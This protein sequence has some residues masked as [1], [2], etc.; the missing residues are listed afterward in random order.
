M[1]PR[2]RELVPKKETW[3][4]HP[5]ALYLSPSFSAQRSSGHSRVSSVRPMSSPEDPSLDEEP[6]PIVEGGEDGGDDSDEYDEEFDGEDDEVGS[7]SSACAGS[8]EIVFR[9]KTKRKAPRYASRVAY[10][11]MG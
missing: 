2:L 10:L 4:I 3:L 6:V 8:S 7:S 5:K 9:T 11:L 1:A